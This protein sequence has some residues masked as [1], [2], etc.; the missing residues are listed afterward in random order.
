MGVLEVL[1]RQVPSP[2]Y[3]DSGL[4]F[5]DA[6]LKSDR[7][8]VLR[9]VLADQSALKDVDPALRDQILLGAGMTEKA[10]EWRGQ[11]AGGGDLLSHFSRCIPPVKQFVDALLNPV[12]ITVI[13]AKRLPSQSIEVEFSELGG[14]THN[15]VVNENTTRALREQLATENGL[16]PASL[17]FL[18]PLGPVCRYD[19]DRPLV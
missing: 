19:S 9:A 11:P 18:L 6:E 17:N 3:R 7:D 5:A 12:F 2:F 14:K 8:F 1:Q 10:A 13:S 15:L 16:H 4:E